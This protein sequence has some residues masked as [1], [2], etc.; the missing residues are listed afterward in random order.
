MQILFQDIPTIPGIVKDFLKGNF[1]DAKD[2]VF[3]FEN[4]Q[5]QMQEKENSFSENQRNILVKAL[6]NQLLGVSLSEKQKENLRLLGE[7][8]SFTIVT[9]HKLNLFTGPVFFIYKILQTIQT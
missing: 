8:N 5:K 6:A 2:S 7:E 3:S 9:G 1:S 4:I